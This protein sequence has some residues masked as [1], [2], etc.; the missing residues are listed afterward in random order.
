M[1]PT[2]TV[3]KVVLRLHILEATASDLGSMIGYPSFPAV[4]IVT[5][6]PITRQR[7][8]KIARNKYATNSRVD[9][10]LGNTS[11]TRTQQ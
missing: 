9:P 5:R 7:L 1:S 2:I 11:S 8:G 10:L 6:M 4:N 3:Q